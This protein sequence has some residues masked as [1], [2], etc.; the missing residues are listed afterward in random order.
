MPEGG[1]KSESLLVDNQVALLILA[2][3]ARTRAMQSE[4]KWIRSP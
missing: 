1:E 3:L 2:E 4:D